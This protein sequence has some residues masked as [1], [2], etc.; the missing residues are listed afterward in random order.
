MRGAGREPWEPMS[1][2]VTCRLR[3]L[4]A[5]PT[6]ARAMSDAQQASASTRRS[7][8]HLSRH[9]TMATHAMP[10]TMLHKGVSSMTRQGAAAWTGAIA[11]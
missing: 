3:L 8:C 2:C 4:L 10:V 11:H 5:G 6:E 7:R 1:K 9:V